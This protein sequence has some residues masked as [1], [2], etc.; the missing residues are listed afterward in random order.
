MDTPIDNFNW[1]NISGIK[2][3]RTVWVWNR[4]AFPYEQSLPAHQSTN[5]FNKFN[6]AT[7]G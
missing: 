5:H 3:T 7:R 6:L 4:V 2:F 1:H